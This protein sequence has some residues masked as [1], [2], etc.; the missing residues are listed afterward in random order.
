MNAATDP[1]PIILDVRTPEEYHAGHLDGAQLVNYLDGEVHEA[2][3]QLD[4]TADYLVYCKSGGRSGHTVELMQQ[5]GFTSAT[6]LG[7]LEE[8]AE[9]TGIAVVR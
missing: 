6:N 3:P 9:A 8:A 2:I 1:Q 4:P 7:A 5:A